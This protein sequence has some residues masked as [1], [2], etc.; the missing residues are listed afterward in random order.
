MFNR[1]TPKWWGGRGHILFTI[2]VFVTLASLDNAALATIPSMVL[3]ITEA[4]NTSEAAIGFL[5]G[6]VI[7]VTALSAVGWGYW[8]D[9]S[10]RKRLLFWGT[11]VWAAGA[12]L[13][14]TANYFW[15]LFLWQ[16]VTAIGLGVIASVGFSVVSDF[17]APRRRGL[18]MSFWGL[19][20]GI[21][22]I[23]G[24]LLASQL[25]ADDFSLALLVIAVLGAATAVLYLFT[26]DP[27]RGLREPAL[28]EVHEEGLG[29]E[30]RIEPEQIP[31]L[32][33]RRTNLW[34]IIQGLSAQVAYGSLI[35]VPLL[36][37]EKVLA[38]GYDSATATKVGGIFAAIFQ[39]GGLFSIV[40]GH[41]GDRVQRRTLRG[42]AIVSAVGI[43][44]AIPFFLMF[45]FIPL[46]GLDVTNGAGTAT[47][48]PEVL[49]NLVTNPWAAGAF[50]TALLAVAFTGADSPNWFA[51]ISDVNLPEHRGTIFGLANFSN[52]VGRAAGNGLTGAVAG[53]IERAIPPP[54]NWAVGLSIFQV[55]FLPTG[56]C[57]YRAAGTS[58]GDIQEV[59]DILSQRAAEAAG[60]TNGR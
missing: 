35:W 45:F 20:Q 27:P 47:L 56:Y 37:Q 23:V 3:P 55:F 21:G 4:L 7:F 34:L 31:A 44:G 28:A 41:I 48:V 15:Q 11:V 33:E 32:F 8:G 60:T 22:G 39:L 59:R 53:A 40:A 58:P 24:G 25:G 29:Y 26:Y 51:L 46:R 30:Y 43:L 42:R 50:L 1:P 52:G 38:V 6:T 49:R 2:V 36:Y 10:D 13:S 18:A 14:S 9:R 57:Y 16:T 5:T 17:V 54:L 12:G 19:S